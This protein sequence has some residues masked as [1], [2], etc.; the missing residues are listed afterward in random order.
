MNMFIHVFVCRFFLRLKYQ[1]LGGVR[2]RRLDALLQVL[3]GLANNYFSTLAQLQE[4]GRII[5]SMKSWKKELE[6]SSQRLI[7][8]GWI[9]KVKRKDDKTYEVPSEYTD[10]VQ[11]TVKP[12]SCHCTCHQGAR[13]F[14]CKHI[15]VT[16]D[17]H[18]HDGLTFPS[19]ETH[20]QLFGE[21][22]ISCYSLMETPGDVAFHHPHNDN[23]FVSVADGS[24]TC[25][26]F[27][28]WNDCACIRLA[29]EVCPDIA[30]LVATLPQSFEVSEAEAA[31]SPETAQSPGT[32]TSKEDLLNRLKV[33]SLALQSASSIPEGLAGDVN[34]IEARLGISASV[35][36]LDN[37]RRYQPLHAHR[38][39]INKRKRET[40]QSASASSETGSVVHSQTVH[41]YARN[42][43][44]ESTASVSLPRRKK[45]T[46]G[47]GSL[48]KQKLANGLANQ[49]VEFLSIT[50]TPAAKA[51]LIS[52]KT[53]TQLPAD[54]ALRQNYLQEVL[55]QTKLNA[56]GIINDNAD[57]GLL[58]AI[59]VYLSE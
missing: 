27:S 45:A 19:K 11:Y 13:G 50:M 44:L 47:R 43:A 58:V 34:A 7:S 32:A 40:R 16:L 5:P 21:E 52:T 46:S 30:T 4:S 2:N 1:F 26:A 20:I 51:F 31:L 18:F 6:I 29:R 37:S 3:L 57:A 23:V 10:G 38:A 49:T 42:P 53:K 33:I 9:S 25:T 12:G 56:G 48:K 59:E 41:G 14:L 55:L 54:A 28:Y 8:R 24:C 36:P 39:V 17:L 22:L 15:Q 35:R